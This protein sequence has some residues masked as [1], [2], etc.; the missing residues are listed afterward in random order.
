M[1]DR[2]PLNSW[3]DY[4]VTDGVTVF[5]IKGTDEADF[6][7]NPSGIAD[8]V[9][10]KYEEL[11]SAPNGRR[12]CVAVVEA[13]VAPSSLIR[14]IYRLFKACHKKHGTLYVCKFP[15]EYMVSLSTLALSG[16]PGFETRATEEMAVKEILAEGRDSRV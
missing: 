9:L 7:E 1:H 13:S 14:L 8:E 5:A 11:S 6:F 4:S 3:V 12:S 16:Q 2:Q 10:A 15:E